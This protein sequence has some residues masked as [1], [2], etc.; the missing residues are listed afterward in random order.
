MTREAFMAP[1]VSYERLESLGPN[2]SGGKPMGTE[3]PVPITPG[4][5]VSD[6]VVEDRTTTADAMAAQQLT[7][8]VKLGIDYFPAVKRRPAQPNSWPLP[9]SYDDARQAMVVWEA[10]QLGRIS[11]DA[12]VRHQATQ[13]LRASYA[14]LQIPH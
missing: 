9:S 3:P 6:Y 5:P 10:K 7:N 12:A 11:I 14:R 2:W 8:A 13:D 1:Y 4:R